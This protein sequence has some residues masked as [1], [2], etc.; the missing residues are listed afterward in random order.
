MEP[1]RAPAVVIIVAVGATL[2]LVTTLIHATVMHCPMEQMKANQTLKPSHRS[3]LMR[4]AVV[5][6]AVPFEF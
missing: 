3:A 1:E 4:V 6:G 5:C 2:I